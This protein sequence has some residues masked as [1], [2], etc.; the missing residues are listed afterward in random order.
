MD[1]VHSILHILAWLG[2]PSKELKYSIIFYREADSFKSIHLKNPGV[3]LREN[4]V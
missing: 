3:V 1:W 2:L 4:G